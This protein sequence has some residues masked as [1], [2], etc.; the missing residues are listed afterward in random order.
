MFMGR[1]MLEFPLSSGQVTF[2]DEDV[3]ALVSQWDWHAQVRGR[4][5][6]ARRNTRQNGKTHS[7]YPGHV[8]VMAGFRLVGQTKSGRL[9]FQLKPERMPAPRPANP[10]SL[11]GLPLF[12]E[13]AE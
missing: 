7:I 1:S 9:A 5:V 13:A 12:M 4:L 6:Y 11:L 8:Y 3:L 2:I 10:R